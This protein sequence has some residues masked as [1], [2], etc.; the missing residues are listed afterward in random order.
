MTQDTDSKLGAL[1]RADAPPERDTLFRIAVVEHRERRRYRQ[2]L[3]M[4]TVVSAALAVLPAIV[5]TVVANR[6][7][8]GLIALFCVG[9]LAAGLFS[10]RGVLQVVRGLRQDARNG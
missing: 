4:L 5:L 10:V 3:T 1:L 9:L 2:P 6:L 8:A 7:E